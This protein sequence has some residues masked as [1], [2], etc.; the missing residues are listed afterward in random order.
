MNFL[1]LYREKQ[2][3]KIYYFSTPL[4]RSHLTTWIACCL[5]KFYRWKSW[6]CFLPGSNF[7]TKSGKKRYHTVVSRL[8]DASLTSF[9]IVA[10][11][12]KA[13]LKEAS[14]TSNELKELND[15]SVY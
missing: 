9:Y 11:A 6:W 2:K 15:Q 5:V 12:D 1:V 8:R 4:Q 3:E 10:R 13:S 7:C 14:R